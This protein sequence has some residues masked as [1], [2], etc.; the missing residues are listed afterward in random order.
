VDGQFVSTVSLSGTA[1]TRRIVWGSQAL[2]YLEHHLEIKTLDGAP[3]DID[4]IL[5]IG[6]V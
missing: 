4:A 6:D 3:V 2:S 1:Q 5:T